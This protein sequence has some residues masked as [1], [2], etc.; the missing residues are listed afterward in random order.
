M[1]TTDSGAADHRPASRRVAD[2]IRKAIEQGEYSPGDRLPSYRELVSQHGIAMGTAREVMRLLERDGLAD[3]RHGS[4]AYVRER[5]DWP[6]D[7]PRHALRAEMNEVAAIRT[8]LQRLTTGLDD[9]ERRL[10]GL[11]RR[12][13][14]G[15]QESDS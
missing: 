5:T 6:A 3:I 9:V 14:P 12:I 8:K 1:T 15:D 7:D 13:G 2:T 10:D 4:G 11:L